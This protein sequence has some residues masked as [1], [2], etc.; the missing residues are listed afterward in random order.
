[1]LEQG[2]NRDSRSNLILWVVV[3]V[4]SVMGMGA[5][6]YKIIT[7]EPIRWVYIISEALIFIAAGSFILSY[8]RRKRK[9]EE[10]ENNSDKAQN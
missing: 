3:M 10:A 4:L 7:G 1:M 5:D 2:L 9:R 8:F 6:A